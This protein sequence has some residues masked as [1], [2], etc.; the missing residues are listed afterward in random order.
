MSSSPAVSASVPAPAHRDSGKPWW[1]F[2]HV[3]LVLAGPV[4]VVIAGVIT[5]IIAISDP[6]PVIDP[7]YYRNGI[8]INERLSEAQKSMVPAVTGRTHA[9]TPTQDLPSNR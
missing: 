9:V 2:A 1:K 3:W 7:D 6:D 5:A 4:V 8:E